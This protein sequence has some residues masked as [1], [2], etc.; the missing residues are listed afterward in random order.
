MSEHRRK[1]VQSAC[2]MRCILEQMMHDRGTLLLILQL[3]GYAVPIL[4]YLS[5][6]KPQGAKNLCSSLLYPSPFFPPFFAQQLLHQV[7][8]WQDSQPQ[9]PACQPF[10]PFY[11]ACQSSDVHVA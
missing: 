8:L 3:R 5:K 9:E 4:N 10:Y 11:R 1:F 6:G 7:E 2:W